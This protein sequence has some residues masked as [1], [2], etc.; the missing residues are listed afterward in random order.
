MDINGASFSEQKGQ[1]G[2]ENKRSKMWW[3]QDLCELFTLNDQCCGETQRTK[4]YTYWDKTHPK[5]CAHECVCDNC[6]RRIDL[7]YIPDFCSWT[8]PQ[9]PMSNVASILGQIGPKC[10]KSVTF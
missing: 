7:E 1:R 9:T 10:D 4:K 5:N 8:S 2:Q 3:K 6:E